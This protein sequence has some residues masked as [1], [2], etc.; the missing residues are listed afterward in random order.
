VS[1]DPGAA[2]AGVVLFDTSIGR[3]GIG[4]G[5]RG[6][7]TVQLPGA[8]DA[9]TRSRARRFVT[10][11]EGVAPAVVVE[12][13]RGIRA[14]LDGEPVDLGFVEL[15]LDGVPDFQRRVYEV[16]R[17]IPRGRTMTYG[18][19]ASRLGEPGSA[20]AV[21]QALGRNPF[22]IVVPCHRVLAAGGKLGGFSAR[23]GVST[24]R[25]LLALEGAPA[26]GPPSLFDAVG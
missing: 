17:T 6:V 19:V 25:R 18:E 22:A 16:A 12:A 11:G 9:A 14:L 1:C 5:E 15:D 7:V 26:A 21:G 24:K 23:G 3:C 8:T 13:I 10:G 2:R 4:W 20:R